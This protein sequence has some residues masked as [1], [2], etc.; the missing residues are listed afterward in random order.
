MAEVLDHEKLNVMVV[1]HRVIQLNSPDPDMG[2]IVKRPAT[3]A[4]RVTPGEPC[5]VTP[6]NPPG[7]VSRIQP[8][9]DAFGTLGLSA[10]T[11]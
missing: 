1:S 4:L 9:P 6:A 5:H 8:V 2:S 7:G 3:G 11:G 10:K